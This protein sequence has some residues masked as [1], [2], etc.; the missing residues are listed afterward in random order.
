MRLPA[1]SFSEAETVNDLM[2]AL[3]QAGP[4]QGRLAVEVQRAAIAS[5]PPAREAR[6][7]IEVLEWHAARHQ[8]RLHL[9]VLQDE[10]TVLGTLTYAQLASRARSVARGLIERDI[11]PGDRVALMLPTSI[12]FFAAFFGILYADAVPVPIYPPL[13]LSQLED[14][15]RRQVGILRNAGARLLITMPEGKRLARLLRGQLQ[16]LKAVDSV[17]DLQGGRA[18]RCPPHRIQGDLVPCDPEAQSMWQWPR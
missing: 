2:H 11:A 13:R 4:A 16:D 15:L 17:D 7:L 14:H 10:T 3:E 9:T 12:D 6:T 8:D 18:Q 5:V 1:Q